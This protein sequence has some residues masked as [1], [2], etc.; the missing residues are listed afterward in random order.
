MGSLLAAAFD[1]AVT[2]LA[3]NWKFALLLYAIALVSG[4]MSPLF[5]VI[6]SIVWF[7]SAADIAVREVRPEFRMDSMS[8]GVF[9]QTILAVNIVSYGSV[10]AVAAIATAVTSRNRSAL[11]G[12]SLS[13][14]R[15][16]GAFRPADD[17]LPASP[18]VTCGSTVAIRALFSRCRISGMMTST[19]KAPAAT[20]ITGQMFPRSLVMRPLEVGRLFHRRL[21]GSFLQ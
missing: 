19:K 2:L 4:L 6:V 7:F 16:M 18:I 21:V 11:R 5:P 10:L 8:G 1:R 14:Q 13:S 9:F 20:E 15:Y 17:S 3:R 12:T